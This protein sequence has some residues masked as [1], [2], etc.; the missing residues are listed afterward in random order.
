MSEDEP[1]PVGT[2]ATVEFLGTAYSVCVPN[3]DED[4]IQ[5]VLAS[6]GRPYEELMLRDMANLLGEGDLLVDV[7]AN[8]GNHTL[9]LATATGCRVVAYEPNATLVD[10]LDRS[11]AA[12]GLAERIITRRVGVGAESARARLAGLNPSNLGGQHLDIDASGGIEIVRLDDEQL[13]GA[14]VL[15]ID[16]EGMELD[17]LAGA[18]RTI[19]ESRP[20]IFVE[21]AERGHFNALLPV[22]EELGYVLVGSYNATPTHHFTHRD[23]EDALQ[24]V[25]RAHAAEA[26]RR[27][28]LDREAREARSRLDDAA[29]KYRATQD[30]LARARTELR[31]LAQ[32]RDDES[33]RSRG[34]GAAL[35]RLSG[36]AAQLESRIAA[37]E[38][39]AARLRKDARV[40]RRELEA[41]RARKAVRAANF[42]AELARSPRA[43]GTL[44]R[45]VAKS[46]R[47]RP[48]GLGSAPGGGVKLGTLPTTILK[49]EPRFSPER[50]E[51]GN[52]RAALSAARLR[53]TALDGRRLRVAAIM[54]PFT[55]SGF[56]HDCDLVNLDRGKWLA[57]IETRDPDILFV[58]SAWRG[59]GGSWHNLVP[60]V[61]A[62]LLELLEWCRARAVP[63]VFW[64]KEDPIHFDTFLRAAHEFDYV[65]TTDVDMVP[66]YARELGHD[67]VRLLPFASQPR[68]F[69]PL[70]AGERRQAMVFAGGYYR[71]YADRMRDL[72]A[73]LEGA[74]SVL[75]VE[76]YDRNF[77]TRMVDYAFPDRFADL[78]VG[79]LAPE[80]V[81]MA[82]KRYQ[83]SLNLNSVKGSNSMFARRVF[84]T[85]MCATP[86][87]SNYARGLSVVFGDLVPMSDDAAGFAQHLTRLRDDVDYRDRLAT[88]GLRKVLREHTYAERLRRI[89]CHVRGGPYEL[90]L[91]TVGVLCAVS[92]AAELDGVVRAARSQR[93]VSVDL[94]V[95][96]DDPHVRS[97][98][99]RGARVLSVADAASATVKTVF[100]DAPV[101]VFDAR[102]MYLP[103]YLSGLL[104]AQLYAA[105]AYS[106]K[107]DHFASGED[108]VARENEGMEHVTLRSR[109]VA[110]RRSLVPATR[111]RDAELASLLASSIKVERGA[112][113]I[114]VDRFDYCLG[115][116]GSDGAAQIVTSDLGIDQGA[117]L[118]D[119]DQAVAALDHGSSAAERF[120]AVVLDDGFVRRAR[121]AGFSVGR[122]GF[123]SV[124]LRRFSDDGPRNLWFS[125]PVPT[126]QSG[127]SIPVRVE[128]LGDLDF[129]GV[130]RWRDGRGE[131]LRVD[132]LECEVNYVLEP[133]ERAENVQYGV[134]LAGLGT[135][136]L[137]YF[138]FGARDS[139]P[140]L[141]V[142]RS[143]TLVL[144]DAY[145]SASDLYKYGFVHSR[146]RSY[147]R[148]G[149]QVDVFRFSEFARPGFYSFEDVAVE[150]GGSGRL[151]AILESGA[152]KRILVHFLNP[153]V[154]EILR[155]FADRID[156]TVWVHGA[157][158]QPWWRRV[159]P[160]AEELAVAKDLTPARLDFWRDVVDNAPASTRLVVVSRAFRDEIAEDLGRTLDEARAAII[161]NPIDTHVFPYVEKS[162]EDRLR[163]VSV[164]P[165]A[166]P[167]Y[168]ND[169]A[170]AAVVD[171]ADEAWFSELSFTFVG[172]GPYFE[173]TVE[174]LRRYPNVHLSEGFL[175]QPEIARLYE[176]KGVCLVPTRVD[177]QGV[178]RDEAMASGLVPV[179]SGIPAVHEFVSD[180]EGYIA[181]FDDHC[182]LADAI[183]DMYANPHV[184]LRKS[185]A[186]AERVRSQTSADVVTAREIEV[187]WREGN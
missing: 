31:A 90:A 36:E 150:K 139:V 67:R 58:E 66:H 20:E 114:S 11:V 147:R 48:S 72:D 158:I 100:S 22:M 73:A 179:T 69:N 75:P 24:M 6:T 109:S 42:A 91:P 124:T 37:L 126:D 160:S 96:T 141:A 169:L 119:L 13:D 97:R 101:A 4:Y 44:P 23:S 64:N 104:Q 35:S 145:P 155:D 56:V 54:D 163:I 29:K 136:S 98:V 82:H 102:D 181:P 12:N 161:H 167:K 168:A 127:D 157:E 180:R 81:D 62:E 59:A 112:A 7:G 178:S 182:G 142:R 63:T 46:L 171:L 83:V 159:Y 176:D 57:Q 84:E 172:A 186:A 41:A 40:S 152:Y 120:E 28:D 115:A 86:T 15:K 52:E 135:V 154:W 185:R 111:L 130:V 33:R 32:E 113:V 134:R 187:G 34:L 94:V 19:V 144:A 89:V 118:S 27:Y 71:R 117:S 165:Y 162:A 173:E 164:R 70:D 17:V 14:R 121:A 131:V 30:Q 26:A 87:V 105:D 18:R 174:P 99:P 9:A 177:S 108:G 143:E 53:S 50:I 85:L 175:T 74:R 95:V 184:F 5:G 49:D 51:L 65:Y 153:A 137:R 149:R 166:G 10:G 133:P 21:A 110:T 79:T 183:R 38:A 107:E 151:R 61:P 148:E 25:A 43:L 39:Q 60:T 125:E 92:S 170:V 8:I 138:A 80:D 88:N 106:T 123:S 68:L 3:A 1:A 146:V 128:A 16:V 129:M 76:I 103:H 122:A 140:T 47:K 93:G 116:A 45:K 156:I 55:E 78:I 77:G 2:F 132:R